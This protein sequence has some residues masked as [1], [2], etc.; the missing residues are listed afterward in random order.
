MKFRHDFV[1][2]EKG[3]S[4]CIY[5]TDGVSMRL[6]LF[7]HILRVALVK[8]GARLL[9]TWSVCPDGACPLMGNSLAIRTGSPWRRRPDTS[10][11]RGISRMQRDWRLAQTST[12]KSP[13]RSV[14]VVITGRAFRSP[15]ASRASSLPPPICPDRTGI[16]YRPC[17]STTRTQGSSAL[18]R[19]N[20]AMARVGKGE[21]SDDHF[22][23][24]RNSVE[25]SSAYRRDRE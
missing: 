13:F 5:R 16:T 15:A 3:E 2:S 21:S 1:L 7:D 8:D 20:G 9:P 18:E 6:D 10:L 14:A 12:A 22:F 11:I 24:S 17:S 25:K 23:A 4:F 19:A